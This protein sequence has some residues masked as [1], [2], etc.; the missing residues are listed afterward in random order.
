MSLPPF[1]SMEMPILQ[2]LAATGGADNLR[3]LYQRLIAYCPQLSE[4]EIFEIENESNKNWRTSIQR[5]GK[6]LEEK[7]LIKRTRGNWTLTE[8]G[9]QTVA[10]ESADFELTTK[11]TN[12][13]SHVTIQIMLVEIGEHLN[14]YAET[15]FE[16]YDVIWRESVGNPRISHIFEVQSKGNIDSAFAKLKRAF[17]AQRSKPFLIIDSERH[18]NRSRQS[19]EREFSDIR[20]FVTILTFAQVHQIHQNL[21]QIS[22]FV[23]ILLS[24]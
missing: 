9:F 8:K 1:S 24:R 15:E 21:S 20:D 10:N 3:F 18:S 7:Q 13:L 2:E 5:A 11:Q 14:F 4:T 23:K 12:D 16:F 6:S 17:E 19:L 22:D